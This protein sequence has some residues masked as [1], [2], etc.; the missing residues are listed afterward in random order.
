MAPGRDRDASKLPEKIP[1]EVRGFPEPHESGRFVEI[2]K[3]GFDAR[4]LVLEL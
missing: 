1:G 3:L 4:D 2:G